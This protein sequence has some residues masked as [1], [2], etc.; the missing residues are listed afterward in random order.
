MKSPLNS[1]ALLCRLL[2]VNCVIFAIGCPATSSSKPLDREKL[3]DVK[4][5]MS[6]A[7]VEQLLGPSRAPRAEEKDRLARMVQGMPPQM[8]SSAN[9]GE[10]RAW[11]DEQGWFV[12][13]FSR[14]EGKLW[15]MAQQFGGPPPSAPNTMPNK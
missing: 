8:Q 4:N 15:M 5:G 12:G 6:L 13:R 9:M 11:G 2:A 1:V 3:A 10:D 14:E 7:D